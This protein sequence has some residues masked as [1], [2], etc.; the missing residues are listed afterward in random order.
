MFAL[1][2]CRFQKYIWSACRKSLVFLDSLEIYGKTHYWVKIVILSM[3]F[4]AL[5]TCPYLLNLFLLVTKARLY[6]NGI[7]CWHPGGSSMETKSR[8][9]ERLTKVNCWYNFPVGNA[10]RQ[11]SIAFQSVTNC[12][13]DSKRPSLDFRRILQLTEIF[14]V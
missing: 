12:C 5:S 2:V 6:L 7:N 4:I 11:N 1:F 13:D 10:L 8:A 9:V 14:L 3:F